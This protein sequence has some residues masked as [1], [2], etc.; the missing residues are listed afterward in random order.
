MPIE[1][2]IMAHAM[3]ENVLD[4]LSNAGN[5]VDEHH[6]VLL[7]EAVAEV[8]RIETAITAL[9]TTR[10]PCVMTK[11]RIAV[12][13]AREQHECLEPEWLLVESALFDLSAIVTLQ[14]VP[15]TVEMVA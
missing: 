4:D 11:L 12:N 8:E 6:D 15:Q 3:A 7:D 10:L 9:R 1:D 5:F 2:L 14:L 13:R